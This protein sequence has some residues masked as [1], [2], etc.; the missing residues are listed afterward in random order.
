MRVSAGW[1]YEIIVCNNNSN[2][3]T[4]QVLRE[5]RTRLPLREVFEHKQGLSH[6]RNRALAVANGDYIIWTDDDVIVDS[7]WLLAYI[8]AFE[9][10]PDAAIFGGP[11]IPRFEA[12]PPR[13]I[14]ESVAEL[15]Y[16]FAARDLGEDVIPLSVCG[17]NVPF[18]A[19]F[20][21]RSKEQRENLFDIN[22]GPGA[23]R[24]GL[25]DETELIE[26]LLESG[27]IG[28]WVPDAKVTHCIG[29]DRQS[30]RYITRYYMAHGRTEAYRRSSTVAADAHFYCGVPRWLIR[31][32]LTGWCRYRVRRLVSPGPLWVKELKKYA[33]CKGELLYWLKREF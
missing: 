16:A 5:Y 18:G 28:C 26:R 29:Q 31:Q 19:N 8:T 4:N 6:A 25:G 11:I 20:A 17:N 21:V 24:S 1:S 2:D 3:H 23:S 32:L 7:E 14:R 27:A 30:V 13:W 10:W 33:F 22:L 15:G 9:R 12:P